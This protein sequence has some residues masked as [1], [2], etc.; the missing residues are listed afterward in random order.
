MPM[1][2][3]GVAMTLVVATTLA[4][5]GV[6]SPAAAACTYQYVNDGYSAFPKWS[7][8][9]DTTVSPG[10]F[11][12]LR[13]GDTSVAKAKRL[14]YLARNPFCGGSWYGINAGG[15]WRKN[16]GKVVAWFAGSRKRDAKTT[17]GLRPRDTLAKAR[18]LYP[19]LEY[20]RFVKNIFGGPGQRVYSTG[21]GRGWLDVYVTQGRS[22]IDYFSVRSASVP[23]AVPWIL[24]GC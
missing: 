8:N 6:T 1:I 9:C 14:N 4:G 15:N 5:I 16:N 23:R 2:A 10:K 3:P 11:G 24:D 13:M 18:R 20:T 7:D 12:Q 22:R 21:G 19:H 17:R